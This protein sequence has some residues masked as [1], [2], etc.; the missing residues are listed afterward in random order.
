MSDGLWVAAYKANPASKRFLI[1]A[2]VFLSVTHRLQELLYQGFDPWFDLREWIEDEYQVLV[3]KLALA[4]QNNDSTEELKAI[5]TDSL[6]G[7]DVN[8]LFH[9]IPIVV[10]NFS[11]LAALYYEA[12]LLDPAPAI[13]AYE[14]A[15]ICTA[16]GG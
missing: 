13:P 9:F 3:C 15:D 14:P 2:A 5:F 7:A 16:C 12:P 8:P 10:T 6:I 11:S 1:P 4:V